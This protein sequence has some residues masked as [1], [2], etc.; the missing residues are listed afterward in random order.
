VEPST[1]PMWKT[2]V[3]F[4]SL[5]LLWVFVMVG[6]PMYGPIMPLA[7][8]PSLLYALWWGVYRD[9]ISFHSVVFA[10]CIGF[11]PYGIIVTVYRFI[12]L[13]ICLALLMS[14]TSEAGW[15]IVV[16]L[17]CLFGDAMASEYAKY[18]ITAKTRADH[19]EMNEVQAYLLYSTS[20]ALGLSTFLIIVDYWLSY[21]GFGDVDDF[22]ISMVIRCAIDIPLQ[23]GTGYLIGLYVAKNEIYAWNMPP[24]KM[25]LIPV[26]LRVTS[27]SAFYMADTWTPALIVYGICLLSCAAAIIYQRKNVPKSFV[28]LAG[29]ETE[30]SPQPA[31]MADGP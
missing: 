13:L 8:V 27:E 12:I 17:Y 20:G 21:V 4:V 3:F 1:P 25:L 24:W 30:M 22:I 23:F 19:R 6:D 11:F 14:V 7:F 9:L 15:Y 10:Y 26:T 18:K 16:F 31:T 29:D 28:R 2:L 5:V